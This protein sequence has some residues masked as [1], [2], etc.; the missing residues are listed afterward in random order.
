MLSLSLPL[1]LLP[2]D[3]FEKVF[4]FW[5]NGTLMYAQCCDIFIFLLLTCNCVA[6][7]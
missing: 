4:F 1:A 3:L 2:E 6:I 5:E 7:Q